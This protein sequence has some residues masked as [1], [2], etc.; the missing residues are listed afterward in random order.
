MT[1]AHLA[2]WTDNLENLKAYYAQYFEG[3]LIKNIEYK[4]L[5]P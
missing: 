5:T 1:L 2:I 3:M 4:M